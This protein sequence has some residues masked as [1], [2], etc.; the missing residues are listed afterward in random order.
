M[1]FIK[2]EIHIINL[3]DTLKKKLY[4]KKEIITIYKIDVHIYNYDSIG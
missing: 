3:K 4:I 1:G 2:K